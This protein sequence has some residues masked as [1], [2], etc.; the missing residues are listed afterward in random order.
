MDIDSVLALERQQILREL[1]STQLLIQE[2]FGTL[3]ATDRSDE[4]FS[5]L[6]LRTSELL[7]KHEGL[8]AELRTVKE[9]AVRS[10][11][12]PVPVPVPGVTRSSLSLLSCVCVI[13]HADER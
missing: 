11:P 4:T 12:V 6:K 3:V 7:R 9:A 1:E 2:A 5:E 8:R 13:A 10:V